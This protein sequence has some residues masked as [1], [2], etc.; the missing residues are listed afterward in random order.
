MDIHRGKKTPDQ[1][2]HD[3]VGRRWSDAL[4]DVGIGQK[5]PLAGFSPGRLI[6]AN[7]CRSR[8]FSAS[9]MSR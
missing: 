2:I 6:S 5:R 9:F 1:A 7:S 3:S 8:A 4:R